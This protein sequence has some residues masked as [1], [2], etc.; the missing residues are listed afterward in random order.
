TLVAALADAARAGVAVVRSTRTGAGHVIAPSQPTPAAGAFVSA[1]DL[2]P[3]KARVALLLA[4][5]AELEARRG[6][7]PHPPAWDA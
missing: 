7:L 2:N 1:G 4:L 5:G 3:Y 6:P